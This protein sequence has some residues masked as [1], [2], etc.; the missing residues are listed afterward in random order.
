M[1]ALATWRSS[2]ANILTAASRLLSRKSQS[3]EM[4]FSCFRGRSA[5]LG[6]LF[7]WLAGSRHGF[8]GDRKKIPQPDGRRD[9]L[10]GRVH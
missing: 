3:R 1:F 10:F 9:F 6:T 7:P 4:V 8:T 2:L 5:F